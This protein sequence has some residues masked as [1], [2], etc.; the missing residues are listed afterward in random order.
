MLTHAAIMAAIASLNF[1][2]GSFD[3]D[4]AEGDTYLSYLPLAHIF[5]RC[6]YHVVSIAA[7]LCHWDSFSCSISSAGRVE[8]RMS[9]NRG[10]P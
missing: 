3:Q 4:F 7:C 6:A 2:L 10:L 1:Y 8:E 9:P 5:D